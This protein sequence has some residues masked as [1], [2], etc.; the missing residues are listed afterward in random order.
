[1]RRVSF[2]W[3]PF[4]SIE[5]ARLCGAAPEAGRPFALIETAKGALRL[6][7]LDPAASAA[8]LCVG[9]TLAD[10]RALLPELCV[11][12]HD[13]EADRRALTRLARWCG[14][15]S[16]YPAPAKG[17]S[18]KDGIFLDVSG[19][20]HLFGGEEALAQDIRARLAALGYS[21]RV[22]LGDG[23]AAA[24]ALA[25]FGPR[26]VC[27]APQGHGL[28]PLQN[29]PIAALR[30]DAKTEQG[31]RALGLKRV[32]Q[33]ARQ[34]RASLARRFGP[35]L[36]SRLDEAA[37]LA[38][39]PIDPLPEAPRRH[40]RRVFAEPLS[41]LDQIAV[42]AGD[43]A[44]R[45]GR[46]LDTQ[47]VGARR[48]SLLLYRVDGQTAAVG[49]GAAR[50]TA[51]G[52]R[53]ARLIA[54]RLEA[55]GERLDPGF[56]VDAMALVAL[57]A[58]RS[59]PRVQ[60]LDAQAAAEGEAEASLA[61]L[62]DRLA[63]TFGA[64]AIRR[65]APRESHLPERAQVRADAPAPFAPDP[66]RPLFLFARPEPVE[67]I[68][69]APDGAPLR[70]RWRRVAHRVA[71]AEGPERLGAEWWRADGPTR[72]Y[73]RVETAEGR[74]FWLFRAGLLGRETAAARWFVHGSFA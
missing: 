1:M 61:D 62:C 2:I 19:V 60:S 3:L 40:V 51:D 36:L 49:V 53:L 27:V 66:R 11:A 5:R 20:A 37:G 57:A 24:W 17:R 30:L 44:R 73:Y 70:F 23:A 8:G 58:E 42:A 56:G 34:S 72:D 59:R 9:Q 46:D 48:L 65:V 35:A 16:P 55:V 69:E 6:A 31:L 63:A 33:L 74:R 18:G 41:T 14:R 68:A 13:A 7:A 26:E 39:E 43:L 50:P 32:G 28:A 15:W 45:L 71:K 67:A 4:W 10:A 47:G 22:G 12:D 54:R 38:A 64:Q 29:S 25:R 52:A 21:A